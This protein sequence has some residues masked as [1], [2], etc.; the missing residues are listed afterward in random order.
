MMAMTTAAIHQPGECESRVIWASMTFR[1]LV[2]ACDCWQS[3][4][5]AGDGQGAKLLAL[6]IDFIRRLVNCVGHKMFMQKFFSCG[7]SRPVLARLAVGLWALMFLLTGCGTW[8]FAESEPSPSA[9]AAKV[10][11]NVVYGRVG[12]EVLTMDV[13]H[14]KNGG[15]KLPLVMYVHGGGWRMGDKD[16]LAL[17]SGP[18]ELLRRGY[19]VASVNYRLAPE[20]KFPAMLEDAKC[21]VRFLRANA[22]VFNLAP[23]HI[24]VMG[25]S[26]GGHLV[27][28]MGLTD[29]SAGFEGAGWTNES[30]RVQ[31]VVDLYGPS[32]FSGGGTNLSRMAV[33]LFKEAFGP[34]NRTDSIIQ[35]ASPMTYV[36][37]HAPPF[38]IFHGNS[39]GR[40][41]INQSLKL[42]ERLLAAGAD[43]TFVVITNYA[44]GATAFARR[45]SPDAL[46]RS[47]LIADFFDRKLR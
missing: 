4:S 29:A 9:V 23:D 15:A 25:D 32:D 30:S 2:F 20:Y 36:S 19:L 46:E 24:G 42:H 10:E 7:E 16:M 21:A 34:T 1:V 47:R 41:D 14:P 44:H 8:P 13:Y 17:M 18:T 33:R 38:L 45:A 28:L 39:D 43:S 3:E 26:A 12:N 40:V 11:R 22:T 31:A 5:N 35:R 6:T 27:A 37:S